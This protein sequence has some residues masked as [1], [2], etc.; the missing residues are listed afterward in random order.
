MNNFCK[1][2]HVLWPFND[3]ELYVQDEMTGL[4]SYSAAFEQ[5]ANDIRRYT[6]RPDLFNNFQNCSPTYLKIIL[7]L[8]P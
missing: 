3:S 6:F 8:T 5:C 7:R 4:Y 2:M 1:Y